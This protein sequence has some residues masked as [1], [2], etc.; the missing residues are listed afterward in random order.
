MRSWIWIALDGAMLAAF[1]VLQVWRFTGVPLHEWLAVALIAAICAHLAVHW[2]WVET[3]TRRIRLPKRARTR[4]N[5]AL[6]ATLFAAMAVAMISGFAISKVVL[7]LHPAPADYVRWHGIHDLASR[8]A[9]AAV[10]LHLALNWGV[11]FRRRP[12]IGAWLRPL[13]W[14]IV[15]AAALT[16]V[17][18]AI[19]RVMPQP[20][21]VMIT[22]QGRIE[23]AAPP[24]DIATLHADQRR[25]NARFAVPLIANA[26]A[27]AVGALIGRRVLRLRID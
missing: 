9:I 19:E 14:T 22:P 21:V 1:V 12:R 10:G 7:P 4:V 15:A 17:S 26:A 16:A 6:N 2:S 20:E 13:A 5:Y 8:I 25:P 3:R 27:V 23:H 11:L 18:A 24:P